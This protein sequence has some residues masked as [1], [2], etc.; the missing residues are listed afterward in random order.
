MFT[1][2]LY[3]SYNRTNFDCT[4][5]VR[6]PQN[7]VIALKFNGELTKEHFF[8]LSINFKFFHSFKT[9]I[10]TSFSLTVKKSIRHGFKIDM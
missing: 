8:P 7:L 2:P 6:V 10:F 1:S 5:T 3:P 4:W 9:L